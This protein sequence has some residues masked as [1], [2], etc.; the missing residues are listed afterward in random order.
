MQ[1]SIHERS[2]TPDRPGKRPRL[3][4]EGESIGADSLGASH[5]DSIDIE[6]ALTVTASAQQKPKQSKKKTRKI[7]HV[8]IEPYSSDDVLY[9]DIIALLKK[10]RKEPEDEWDSPV[11]IGTEIE[12]TVSEL[13]STGDSLSILP[14]PYRPWT[15]AVPF[16]LPGERIRARVFRH[17]RLVSYADLVGVESPSDELRDMSLVKCQYFGK[18]AGCQYQM[19]SYEDQLKFK[20]KVVDKAYENFSELLPELVPSA[21]PTIASPKNYGYRTKIT[22]HFD[23]PPKRRKTGE[24]ADKPW[25]VR[26]GFGEKGR[27]AVLDIEECPIATEV[28]N[29]ALGPIREDVKRRFDTYKKGATLLLRDSLVRPKPDE[30]EAGS[31]AMESL[32]EGFEKHVCITDY[33][34]LIRER[35]GDFLFE[36][37]AGSF[38]QNNNSVLEPLTAYVREAVLATE[39]L[40]TH[41]VDAYCGSGLFSITLS[42]HFSRVAGV[43][44]SKES[45]EYA[46]HNAKLNK[47]PEDKCT[48]HAGKAE[49]I[50][51]SVKD[52]PAAQT[53]IVVDP[54]RK[55][56]DLAFLNQLISF[57]PAAVV[58]VSC[59]VHTQARD[60]GIILKET[61]NK[62]KLE[63]LRGFD[64]FPQTAHVE[65]VAILRKL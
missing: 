45:I 58:Y 15:V 25:D 54:P 43:E 22:P 13:S 5:L 10:E 16:A 2:P 37:P 48:F 52:F 34:A 30:V 49:A 35:V 61:E 47:I 60:V 11:P 42:P 55:G 17:A 65:S 3:E 40:P 44:I 36:Y 18:C 46:K 53:V 31:E 32:T 51:D 19:M 50:F 38:F 27:R 59:N 57:G 6:N 20:K 12:L 28:L 7:K 41:L 1:A 33:H 9:H 64:L 56:C 26:I 14:A 62:Y 23:V 21:L 8:A 63:S 29:E 4:K 24:N 39:T